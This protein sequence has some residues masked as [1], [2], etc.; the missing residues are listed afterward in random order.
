MAHPS[1]ITDF[2]TFGDFLDLL[3]HTEIE[4]I[5]TKIPRQKLLD[6]TYDG[7]FFI[8]L[9]Q[10]YDGANVLPRLLQQCPNSTILLDYKLSTLIDSIDA[11]EHSEIIDKANAVKDA[12]RAMMNTDDLDETE[13][14]D[15]TELENIVDA[16]RLTIQLLEAKPGH[17]RAAC[18]DEYRTFA[19]VNASNNV[20]W[21]IA[22]VLMLALGVAVVAAGIFIAI[23]GAGVGVSTGLCLGGVSIATVGLSMFSSKP[24][25]NSLTA[26]Q[27]LMVDLADEIEALDPSITLIF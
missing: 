4:A 26:E 13:E 5:L 23:T 2:P 19:N 10:K 16:L 25:P 20:N 11:T 6:L 18:L 27:E 12:F 7:T 22:S 9:I 14:F 1:K 15:E 17:D 21:T 8:Q 24:S 3:L